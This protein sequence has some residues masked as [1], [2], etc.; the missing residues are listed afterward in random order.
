MV[1]TDALVSTRKA[2]G[3]NMTCTYI[4]LETTT[5]TS[6]ATQKLVGGNAKH[7]TMTLVSHE[8][9]SQLLQRLH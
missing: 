6:F 8:K 2:G 7:A 3:V 5:S 4:S 1:T 9:G